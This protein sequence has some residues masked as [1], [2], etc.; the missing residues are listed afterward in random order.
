MIVGELTPDDIER[1]MRKMDAS[2][3]VAPGWSILF[4]KHGWL[5]YYSGIEA[6]FRLC[7]GDELPLPDEPK[8]HATF[9]D[10]WKWIQQLTEAEID[11]ITVRSVSGS[12]KKKY[13]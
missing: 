5:V 7:V 13:V 8:S 10:A 6:F 3:S 11:S 4:T 2:Y 12:R 9:A 1:M